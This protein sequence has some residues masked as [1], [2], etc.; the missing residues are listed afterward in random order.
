[1]NFKM[2]RP[3]TRLERQAALSLTSIYALRMLGLFLLFP[4]LALYASHLEGSTPMLIGLALGAY[5]LSQALLQIPFGMLSD[6]FGRKPVIIAGLIL[7]SLGSAIAAVSHTLFG[8]I[9]GRLLQ[10]SGAIAGPVMALAADLSREEQRTKVMAI[11]GISIGL[12]FALSLILGP[13]LNAWIGVPGIFWLI[14]LLAIAAIGVLIV[15]VPS[16]VRSMVHRDA[17][18]VPGQLRAVLTDPQLLR[19]D[20]GILV[21]HLIL[22]ATFV[23]TPLALRDIAGF[24]ASRH[25]EI[26]LPVLILSMA[27][28][29]PF[30]LLAERKRQ[31]KPV[32]AGAVA[33][34]GLAEFGLQLFYHSVAGIVA[35]LWL[36]FTAFNLLEAGLPSLMS[37]LAPP[38]RK[39]TALGVYSTSQFLGAFIGGWLA[40]WLYGRYGFEAVFD[41]CAL[42][43]V[44]W[45]V[46]TLAMPSPQYLSS[47]ILRVG[48]VDEAEARQL[49]ARL[50][51]VPGVAEAVVIVE[52]GVAYL[53]VDRSALNEEALRALSAA[54]V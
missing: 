48:Q 52:E 50:G 13:I 37:K 3:M 1:M 26:Y 25:W 51:A 40:G 36:F 44:L 23:V 12:S 20:F 15:W 18:A 9:A 45:F 6:R 54:R 53:K 7:F 29:L 32:M 28:M 5:G 47:Y 38:D 30:I 49:A 19:L 35:M 10:G 24:P 22:T 31:I 16:P 34:L 2:S 43:T 14:A 4:V 27:A 17:E 42:F 46:L 41:A 33:V 21:L 11:I 39:G 8:V